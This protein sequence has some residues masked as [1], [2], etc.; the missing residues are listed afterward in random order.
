MVKSPNS[1]RITAL[2]P[3]QR[4]AAW[5]S[6]ILCRRRVQVRK[7]NFHYD[8]ARA[9]LFALI[10]LIA[11]EK[12]CHVRNAKIATALTGAWYA[13]SEGETVKINHQQNNTRSCDE[14]ISL[15]FFITLVP[16]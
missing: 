14:N 2:D 16:H 3:L 7:L 11:F 6:P 1:C 10:K 8:L 9:G 4:S 12:L 15:V 5:I 13:V